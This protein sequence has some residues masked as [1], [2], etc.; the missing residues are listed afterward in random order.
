V[1]CYTKTQCG[2]QTQVPADCW[3]HTCVYNPIIPAAPCYDCEIG[4]Y[5]EQKFYEP[6]KK[7]N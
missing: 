7:C 6:S 2:Q 3:F 5:E 1:L 4:Q